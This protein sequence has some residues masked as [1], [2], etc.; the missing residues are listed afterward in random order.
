MGL[1][2]LIFV[3]ATAPV[4]WNTICYGEDGHV[5]FEPLL[6]DHCA[7]PDLIAGSEGSPAIAPGLAAGA[8]CCGPCTDVLAASGQWLERSPAK[9]RD[10]APPAHSIAYLPAWAARAACTSAPLALS[11]VASP[12]RRDTSSGIVLR[13]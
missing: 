12:A 11:A 7:A 6:A 13:C 1:A 9:D 5:A 4:D 8:S 2:V 10:S 3:L